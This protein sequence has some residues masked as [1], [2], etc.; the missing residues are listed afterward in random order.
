[1]DPYNFF[2][3]FLIR[4]Y[5]VLRTRGGFGFLNLPVNTWQFHFLY[6]KGRYQIKN[7][8]LR[9]LHAFAKDMLKGLN[10][11]KITIK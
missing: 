8:G 11:S 2:S 6:S 7:E 1:M 4:A 3:K 5:E 10:Y 9:S